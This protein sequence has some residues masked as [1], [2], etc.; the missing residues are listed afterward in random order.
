MS[1]YTLPDY[2]WPD[3]GDEEKY[4]YSWNWKEAPATPAGASH[5]YIPV[6]DTGAGETITTITHSIHSK[7]ADDGDNPLVLSG[8]TTFDSDQQT[9]V[10][11]ADGVAGE[12]E[13]SAHIVT[14]EGREYCRVAKLTVY[15]C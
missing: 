7:P 13:I 2:R 1:S 10:T 15:D 12:Y 4:E 14:S 3:K 8:E 6:L 5:P 9:K 11:I